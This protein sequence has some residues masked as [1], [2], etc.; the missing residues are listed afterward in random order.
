MKEEKTDVKEQVDKKQFH[1]PIIGV[2][3]AQSV[4]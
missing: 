4:S 3:L 1:M 2:C